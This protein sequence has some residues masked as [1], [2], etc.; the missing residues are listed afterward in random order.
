MSGKDLVKLLRKNGWTLLRIIGSHH[1]MSKG[2]KVVSVP[3]HGS[4]DI[5]KGL[6]EKLLKQVG[7]K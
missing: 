3:V 7:L 5:D 6:L 1:Y 2:P 4:H